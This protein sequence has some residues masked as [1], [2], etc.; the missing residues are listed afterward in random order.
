MPDLIP[1]P[2]CQTAEH[3]RTITTLSRPGG[4]HGFQVYCDGC[5]A[6]GPTTRNIVEARSLWNIF[7]SPPCP[8]CE[9]RKIEGGVD[10][11][12]KLERT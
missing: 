2:C 3:L 11:F 6:R 7:V 10:W 8:E 12:A 5:G 4:H 9:A 1:C